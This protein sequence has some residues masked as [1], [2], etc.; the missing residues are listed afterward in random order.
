M[1]W[2]VRRYCTD[3]WWPLSKILVCSI[4][5]CYLI[6][7]ISENLERNWNKEGLVWNK[8]HQCLTFSEII[9][10]CPGF[11]CRK[12]GLTVW[13]L[14][15]LLSTNIYACVHAYMTRENTFI[16]VLSKDGHRPLVWVPLFNNQ[17]RIC[18]T[19]PTLQQLSPTPW[20]MKSE[21]KIKQMQPMQVKRGSQFHS[22]AK[23]WTLS[24]FVQSPLSN[25]SVLL[26]EKCTVEKNQT[27]AIN[28]GQKK[29]LISQL[30]DRMDTVPVCPEPSFQQL[31]PPPWEMHRGEKSNICN[32]CRSK[33]GLDF[34]AQW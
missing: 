32:Q 17:G 9:S 5:G 26:H 28:A 15:W 16:T 2:G 20:E 25:N 19:E 33:E 29:V 23:G 10:N 4:L 8:I 30:S 34:T 18:W 22:S 12:Q 31:S 27:Y 14:F 11:V 7:W 13:P 1:S 6:F 3:G 21:E 24:P